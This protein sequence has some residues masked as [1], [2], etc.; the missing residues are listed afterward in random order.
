MSALEA[1][2]GLQGKHRF[3][4]PGRLCVEADRAHDERPQAPAEL[5]RPTVG[6]NL[7]F[8]WPT[9]SLPALCTHAD[10]WL[11]YAWPPWSAGRALRVAELLPW[12]DAH[13]GIAFVFLVGN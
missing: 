4:K 8:L 1:M 11:V 5:V 3:R 7:R 12:R 10:R 9:M 6:S 13:I 2:I